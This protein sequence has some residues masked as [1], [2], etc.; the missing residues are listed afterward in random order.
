MFLDMSGTAATYYEKLERVFTEKSIPWQNCVGFSVD[1][2]SVSIG[3][4]NSIKTRI[5]S[6]YWSLYTL[7][8]PCHFIHNAAHH[9]A[10]SL[11]VSCGLDVEGVMI[12]AGLTN[13]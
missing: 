7:V 1:S 9:R 8:C 13:A 11:E 6:Q 12:L 3:K 5:K 10:K 4:H 2:A